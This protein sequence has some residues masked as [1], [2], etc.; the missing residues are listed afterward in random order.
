MLK[1]ISDVLLDSMCKLSVM[2]DDMLDKE[3]ELLE[4]DLG[5]KVKGVGNYFMLLLV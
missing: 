4:V 1:L 5:C 2:V 3:L